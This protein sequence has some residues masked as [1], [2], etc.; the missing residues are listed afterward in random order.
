M[1]AYIHTSLGMSGAF[2]NGSN[3]FVSLAFQRGNVNLL[4]ASRGDAEGG[5]SYF[6]ADGVI[7]VLINDI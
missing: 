5:V 2:N 4:D 7:S 1:L 6:S 3:V